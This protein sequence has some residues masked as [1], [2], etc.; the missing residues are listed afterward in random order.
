[1]KTWCHH[2]WRHPMCCPKEFNLKFC[3]FFAEC[4]WHANSYW[5]NYHTDNIMSDF[6]NKYFCPRLL[7]YIVVVGTRNPIESNSVQM[8]ELLRRY[9]L[10]DHND[11]AL[12]LDVVFF[13]QP[14]GCINVT[15]KRISFRDNNSFVFALTEKDTSRVR[16]VK[17]QTFLKQ[18]IFYYHFFGSNMSCSLNCSFAL[19]DNIIFRFPFL[20][21]HNIV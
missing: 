15:H 21:F 7:D 12:P 16:W 2:R 9:P 19:M 4:I 17:C 14:E 1:M 11:F 13:C 3:F 8:P 5:C 20:Y 18:N 10:Q 6:I